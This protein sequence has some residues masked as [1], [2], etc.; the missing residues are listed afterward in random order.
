MKYSTTIF[1]CMI[2][3]AMVACSAPENEEI[4]SNDWPVFKHYD[5]EHIDKVALPLGG[6][7]TGTV[8]LGGRGDL[9]DWEIMNRPG[10][11]FKAGPGGNRHP[12]FAVFVDDGTKKQSSALLGPVPIEDYECKEGRKP[13]NHGLPRFRN[14][15]FDAA[16]PFGTVNLSDTR[17]P[18]DVKIMGFNPLIP[19]DADASG[20]PV[21]VLKYLITNTTEK[22]LTVSV[23]GVMENF[24]GADGETGY[25]DWKGDFNP[26]GAKDNKNVFKESNVKGIYMYSEGVDSLAE[27]WGT[28][29]LTTDAA[30]DVSYR[31]SFISRSWGDALLDFWD[32]FGDNGELENRKQPVTVHD[33]NAALAVKTEIPAH[34]TKE[35]AFYLSWHFPN[36]KAWSN[37]VVG[38]YYTTQ[39]TDAWDVIDKT[40]PRL[41]EL[42][43]KTIEWVSA[44]VN[45]DLPEVVKEA[46]L[47]NISTLRSQTTF[48]IESGHMMAWEGCMDTRGSCWGSCTHVW[49]YEQA[50]AFLFGDLAKSMREIEFAYSTQE[51][52]LMSFRTNL[53]LSK[54]TGWSLAA[55]DGQ[56]GTIMKMYREWQLSGDDE[57]LDELWPNVKKAVEFCWITGGWD[58]DMDGVMDG[59]QH[60]TMDV[61]YY[62]PNPQ[63][64]LWYLGALRAAEEMA[65]YQNDI[66]FA[67]KCHSLYEKGSKWTDENL[68][69]GEYYVHI[70]QP[71]VEGDSIARGLT[72]S[73]GAK[74][75]RD[76]DY[77]LGEGCLVDQLV[78]QYMAHILDLGYLVKKENLETTLESI[79]KYNHKENMLDHFNPMRS[80]ALGDEAA[81]LMA[82]FPYS[83][84]NVPFPY[85]YEVMTGFE[86]TAAIGMLYEGME[87]EGLSTI[88][89]I[90]KRYDGKKRNPFNEAECGHHYARAMASWAAPIALTGFN[91][92]GVS[93][94]MKFKANEGLYFWSNGYSYG[95]IE[96]KFQNAKYDIRIKTLGGKLEL[97]SF[98]LRDKGSKDFEKV[99]VI[100]DGDEVSF[101]I[102][103]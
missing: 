12:F 62:G 75:R 42:E 66:E 10:K 26:S 47:F 59:C 36:R 40:Q 94:T 78:G 77:Q 83:R 73:M 97:K 84:P 25:R 72:H 38:N 41:Q 43:N 44:F 48:R 61:E 96:I 34:S 3:L 89:D 19:G 67:E 31:T 60:N 27:Q 87:Q 70:I 39:Y 74:D 71:P 14:C 56:M 88:N 51:N 65:K 15:S 8:S 1:S 102:M 4:I 79:L 81:L 13:D 35:V 21:A 46:A 29:A 86:Y 20:I 69:N 50:T 28:M 98:E 45:S 30:N 37:E 7:G 80:Y 6:I 92:S 63:M 32:D 52:G 91:Y 85:F 101:K 16:Y 22:P 57:F 33:P 24:I 68:F 93:K 82:S 49:N 90:R 100:E 76:P 23:C 11:G 103:G 17:M 2:L 9:R 64:E 58:D 53:P 99:Q 54:S 18:I 5:Q 95:T 55:A